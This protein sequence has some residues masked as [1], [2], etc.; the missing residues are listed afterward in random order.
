MVT[1]SLATARWAISGNSLGAFRVGGRRPR[2]PPAASRRVAAAD[3][4]A[5]TSGRRHH[6]KAMGRS[7]RRRWAKRRKAALRWKTF[8]KQLGGRCALPTCCS[9]LACAVVWQGSQA[10]NWHYKT[11]LMPWKNE[12]T[13]HCG[14]TIIEEKACE[15]QH[16]TAYTRINPRYHGQGDPQTLENRS[17][18]AQASGSGTGIHGQPHHQ[19]LCKQ[20][21]SHPAKGHGAAHC[22]PRPVDACAALQRSPGHVREPLEKHTPSDPS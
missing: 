14:G 18:A 16:H 4:I 12:L 10:Q 17:N 6:A 19:R 22:F 20:L 3:A 1:V 5:D 9:A 21:P 15:K 11:Q 2:R 13:A 8:S 7:A